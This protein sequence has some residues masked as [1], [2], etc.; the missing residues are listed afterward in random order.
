LAL[1][2][3]LEGSAGAAEAFKVAT[4][5]LENYVEPG[6]AARA[7][8]PAQSRAQVR[9]TILR[10][11]A[12]V[13]G[14]QEVGTTNAL[15]ELRAALQEEGLN[16]PYWEHVAGGYDTNIF[17]AVLSRFPI[18]ARRPHTQEG[19]LLQ[20]RRFRLTRGIAEVDIQVSHDYSFTLFVAHLKSRRPA[21]EADES[22]IREQEAAIL[23]EKIETRLKAKPN[24]NLV[25]LGDL[26]DVKDARSTRTVIGR[27][28][29]ALID[30]R[31]AEAN[32]D[33]AGSGR[34]LRTIT[35]THFFAKEDTYSRVD[36]ILLSPGMAKEWQPA[37]SYVVAAPNWGL[38]SDHRP[39]LASFDPR[40]R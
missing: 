30:T 6:E 22:E 36:Y 29:T 28:R 18:T 20:G 1:L 13:L 11:R 38:A 37:A 8:K 25:V 10:M 24:A 21:A 33:P 19:F 31:P 12:D 3:V 32:G 39:V 23:R 15:L 14:L 27:G 17:V 9:E 26:N 16:Y 34:S 5:N 7:G 2:L 35:W 4:F 40:D